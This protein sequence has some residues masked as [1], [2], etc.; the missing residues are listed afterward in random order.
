MLAVF[1]R[2]VA[3][4]DV[5]APPFGAPPPVAPPSPTVAP[6]W[7]SYS[8]LVRS[9]GGSSTIPPARDG[10]TVEAIRSGNSS[11]WWAKVIRTF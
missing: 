8:V 10:D 1:S 6:T 5:D 2:A 4:V 7:L 11:H 9:M 3:L